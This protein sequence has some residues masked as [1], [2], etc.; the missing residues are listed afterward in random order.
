M[1]RAETAVSCARALAAQT[2]PPEMVVVA[3]NVSTDDT[4]TS[5]EALSDLPFRLSVIRMPENSGNAGG[6][7]EAMDFA[8]SEAAE[9]VWI[10]DDDSWPRPGALAALLK[11]PLESDVV[12]HALQTDPASDRFTWPLWVV[13]GNGW[14]LAFQ[15]SQLPP[16]DLIASRSSW[17]GA[18]VPKA[19]RD[20]VGPV[21]RALFI[22]GEDEEY[23]W[24]ISE[25][26][27]RFEACRGAILD[28]PGP[29]NMV[30]WNLWGKN[31]FLE[32]DLSDWKLYYKIRNMVWLKKRQAGTLHSVVIATCYALAVSRV[33]GIRRLPLVLAAAS[34]GWRGKLG[35]W[36]HHPG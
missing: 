2:R 33:D 16:G 3:D 36:S 24:R 6:V 13:A 4:V 29:E 7:A 8:F 1:N 23:P 19:V 10:L 12:R 17:T 18:L 34:D 9:A 26:G 11:E 5:L 25:A 20:R 21:N 14:K 30:R 35:K 28:H 22:R 31:L 15:E 32:R 27:F